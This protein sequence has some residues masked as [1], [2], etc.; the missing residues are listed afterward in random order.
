MTKQRAEPLVA[1]ASVCEKVLQETDGVFSVIR[2][3]DT[4]TLKQQQLAP[5][6]D[7][8]TD[9]KPVAAVQILN[10]NLFVS[11]RAGGVIGTHRLGFE[12]RDPHDKITELPGGM[13]VVLNGENGT[14]YVLTFGLPLNSPPGQYWF[15]VLWDGDVL[16]TVPLKLTLEPAGDQSQ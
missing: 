2:L 9:A 8:P 15:D 3:V 7:L 10:L 1:V 16:T 14:N 4:L 12:M 6:P 5:P 13:P 11:L